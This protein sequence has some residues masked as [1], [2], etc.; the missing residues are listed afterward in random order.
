MGQGGVGRVYQLCPVTVQCARSEKDEEMATAVATQPTLRKSPTKPKA[1]GFT[2]KSSMK[3]VE[4]RDIDPIA[5]DI[6][7]SIPWRRYMW[8]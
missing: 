8:Q 2:I 3:N 7:V 4:V 5:T 6:L 1:E